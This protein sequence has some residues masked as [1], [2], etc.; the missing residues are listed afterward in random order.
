[1]AGIIRK[2]RPFLK[3]VALLGS[4]AVL[5]WLILS[6]VMRG[7]GGRHLTGLEYADEVFNELSKG[8]SYFIPAVLKD[9]APLRGSSVD[10]RVT[11]QKPALAPLAKRLLEQAG[12]RV[13]EQGAALA[14]TGDLGAILTAATDVADRLYHNDGE[15]VS[16]KYGAPALEVASAWWYALKPCIQELQKQQRVADAKAV[17]E[18]LTR[19]LE[20]GNNFYGIEPAKMSEHILLVCALLAFYVLYTLWYGFG[21]YEIF[22]GLGLV[23]AGHKEN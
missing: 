4:F 3:G 9:I 14:F 18:V 1:M 6:P 16:E 11:L 5:F 8:S 7:E 22:E 17:D 12:A 23:A 20:P 10:L 19:A 2:K 15:A 13:E 21:I